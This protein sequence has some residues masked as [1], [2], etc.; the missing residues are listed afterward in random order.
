MR[1][2]RLLVTLLVVGMAV[3][4]CTTAR[5]STSAGAGATGQIDNQ[6]KFADSYGG[7]GGTWKFPASCPTPSDVTTLIRSAALTAPPAEVDG[8]PSNHGC[9]YSNQESSQ[10]IDIFEDMKSYIGV[11]PSD[12]G[13]QLT[14]VPSLGQ[15]VQITFRDTACTVAVP[16]TPSGQFKSVVVTM[17]FPGKTGPEVCD[18]A[19][20]TLRKFASQDKQ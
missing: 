2:P 10:A 9:H 19:V 6:A 7:N 17:F 5:N 4:G 8:A 13:T 20:K 16:S 11:A 3:T 15:R 18:S 14:S 1:T 12:S